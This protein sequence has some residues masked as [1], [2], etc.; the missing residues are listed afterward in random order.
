MERQFIALMECDSDDMSYILL[1]SGGTENHLVL[2][3][4][5]PMGGDGTRAGLILDE[6]SITINK[7]TCPGDT[8]ALSPGGI[9]I[10]KLAISLPREN[11]KLGSKQAEKLISLKFDNN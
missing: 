11:S 3:D 1:H 7:N 4:L 6:V 10:G 2:V 5:R 9:R 8:S